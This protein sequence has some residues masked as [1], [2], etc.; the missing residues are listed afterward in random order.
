MLPQG[1]QSI[2]LLL[3]SSTVGNFTPHRSIALFTCLPNLVLPS[4]KAAF[5]Y[6]TK[7]GGISTLN[8]LFTSHTFVLYWSLCPTLSI[9]IYLILFIQTWV[10]TPYGF[11][12][13]YAMLTHGCQPRDFLSS[14]PTEDKCDLGS[15]SLCTDVPIL[16]IV[17]NLAASSSRQT[18]ID[19]VDTS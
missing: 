3:I 14:F 19:S 16:E 18:T 5:C 8:T 7:L 1:Q 10:W 17:S 6:S 2:F 13:L 12:I 15:S 11:W 4:V 9:P